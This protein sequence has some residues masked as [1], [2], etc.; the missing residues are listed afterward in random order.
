MHKGIQ[1]FKS[2]IKLTVTRSKLSKVMSVRQVDTNLIPNE[3][4][5]SA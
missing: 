2:Q 3:T 5:V 4:I 1:T